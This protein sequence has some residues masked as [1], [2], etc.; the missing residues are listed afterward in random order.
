MCF[1]GGADSG[2][3][4][5]ILFKLK[6]T[7]DFSL[8]ACHFHHG[9]RGKEADTDALFCQTVCSQLG[10][11]FYL[12]RADV[13][14][15]QKKS[16]TSLEE[17][18]RDARYS[19]F[20]HLGAEYSIDYFATAHHRND[21]VE[22]VLFHTIRGTSI[23]GLAG[24]PCKRDIFI[25]PLLCLTKQEILLYAKEHEITFRND[26]SNASLCY[27]RNYIRNVV[28]PAMSK[29]N[30]SIDQSVARL[31]QYAAE[32]D[33]FIMSLLPEFEC[34]QNIIGLPPA[35]VRRTVA[36]NYTIFSKK[37]LCY[38]HID[39]IC[40]ALFEHKNKKI[41]LPNNDMAVVQH[42]CF[43]F[44]KRN[45]IAKLVLGGGTL[46]YGVSYMGEGLVRA[47]FFPSDQLEMCR[48]DICE[49][50][51]K[52]IVY[53]LS[54]EIHLSCQ[55]ICGMIRYR[56]RRP[57]DKLLLRGVNR[58]V[59]KLFSEKKVPLHLRELIP[60][61]YDDQGILCIPFVGVSDRV[62]N[63]SDDAKYILRVDVAD[64]H[65]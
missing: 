13:P 1:S 53:N 65:A 12:G 61:F 54:T 44:K 56:S 59:K 20:S 6:D 19:W 22:T 47:T 36:R 11:P 10:I 24:I 46:S 29:I 33:A 55:G 15:L 28:L 31:S 58:S 18:A 37:T 60:I 42:N 2:V 64:I 25:R 8:S 7:M 39:E 32:D 38:Q 49:T 35:I 41:T 17:T 34:E 3:L 45:D 63:R 30:P 21:Q 48:A 16:K 43:S 40:Q 51:N 14:F 62:L 57:G 4:L 5:H 9:I 50:P 27:T 23:K 26:S 52:E